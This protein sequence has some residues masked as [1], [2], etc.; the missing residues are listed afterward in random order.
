VLALQPWLL[1]QCKDGAGSS[2]P[3]HKQRTKDA[4]NYA[5][6][7]QLDRIF[8]SSTSC[9]GVP[10]EKRDEDDSGERCVTTHRM[11]A[12]KRQVDIGK[13]RPEYISYVRSVPPDRRTPTRPQTPDP[14]AS[15][16]KRQFDRQLS[17]W[18]RRLHEYDESTDGAAD[19]SSVGTEDPVVQASFT[20]EAVGVSNSTSSENI[21]L[22]SQQGAALDCAWPANQAQRH[23]PGL[24]DACILNLQAAGPSRGPQREELPVLEYY[25]SSLHLGCSWKS[26]PMKVLVPC[27]MEDAHIFW[28]LRPQASEGSASNPITQEAETCDAEPKRLPVYAWGLQSAISTEGS[29]F[30]RY[31]DGESSSVVGAGTYIRLSM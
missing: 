11:V 16:S 17:E 26:S 4:K 21:S 7:D 1:W 2:K 19:P 18:R 28:Q 13:A 22:I 23:S 9:I 10:R 30:P 27:L 8:T 29:S 14:T 15:V 3:M 31:A 24:T 20:R 5:D 6:R 12:R 25:Q